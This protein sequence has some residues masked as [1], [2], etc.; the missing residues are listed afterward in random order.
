MVTWM[1][2]DMRART[3][4]DDRVAWRT[5]AAKKNH[6]LVALLESWR[7]PGAPS[8]ADNSR[9]TLRDETF[10]RWLANGAMHQKPGVP[11]TSDKGRWALEPHFAD[12]FDPE[13]PDLAGAAAAWREAHLSPEA[14]IR[15]QFALES[16][17]A[18][19]AVSVALPNR[20]DIR[21][22]E[23]GRASLILKGV[24]EDWA[25]AR[26]QK[27]YVI[28][29]SE[30][31]NK[32]F[33]PDQALL[34][35][36]GLTIDTSDLLPDAILAD[37]GDEVQF[38]FIE[39]ANS[40]GVIDEPRQQRFLEWADQHSIGRAKCRFLT[41]FLSRNDPA[42]RKRLKDLAPNSFAYFAAEPGSELAW[43]RL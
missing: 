38:W 41:A 18:K 3:S 34:T 32:V 20:S 12:L 26:L 16:D 37:V 36:L 19:H 9:E 4:E 22:L 21:R 27:P 28:T 40:D 33:V 30:P 39:V 23:A 14:K 25:T 6:N 5:A 8:Y 31:G 24:M 10:R 15:V 43:Y 17:E 11:K 13:T 35:S 42:A 7:V 1:S 29:I 2:E